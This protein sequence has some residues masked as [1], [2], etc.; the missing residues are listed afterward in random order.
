[1]AGRLVLAAALIS[2]AAADGVWR[3]DSDAG[4]CDECPNSDDFTATEVHF[5]C[6]DPGGDGF[7]DSM[8]REAESACPALKRP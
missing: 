1:M 6:A 5:Y 4:A 3:A 7:W 8:R 2:S